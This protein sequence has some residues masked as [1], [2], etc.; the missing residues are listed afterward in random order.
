MLLRE[1]WK[2]FLYL[3]KHRELLFG[4]LLFMR[5]KYVFASLAMSVSVLRFGTSYLCDTFLTL[6]NLT[7]LPQSWE[8][9]K[10][11]K[12]PITL[13]VPAARFPSPVSELQWGKLSFKSHGVGSRALVVS[14]DI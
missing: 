14:L 11:L 13:P 5:A 6:Q 9:F 10:K 3:E 1:K 7:D 12:L 4:G 8:E 2:A